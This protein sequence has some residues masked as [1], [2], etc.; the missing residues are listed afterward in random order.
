MNLGGI[1]LDKKKEWY[2]II[3]LYVLLIFGALWHILGMFETAMEWLTPLV[4]LITGLVPI[5]SFPKY[6]LKKTYTWFGITALITI[7]IEIIGVKTGVIF[8]NYYYTEY[9]YPRV[10]SV[11]LVIGVAWAGACLGSIGLAQIYGRFSSMNTIIQALFIGYLMMLFDGFLEPVAI[12]LGYW[13]WLGGEIPIQNYIAWWI[14]GALVAYP[15]IEHIKFFKISKLAMHS[16][17]AQLIY[18][19]LILLF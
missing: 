1:V 6:L 7:V 11:P 15:I 10:F 14:I 16:M 9:L 18:F 19:S 8:G 17:V 12:K 5:A 4:M 3:A 2:V 13:K